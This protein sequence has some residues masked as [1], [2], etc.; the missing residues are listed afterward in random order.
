MKMRVVSLFVALASLALIAG[1]GGEPP[2]SDLAAA[3]QSLDAARAAGAEKFA[4]SDYS[5]AQSA[6]S[7]AEQSVNTEN[8]KLFKNF[9]QAKQLIT[10]AKGKA[11]R[12][13][14][15]ADSEKGRQRSSAEG[16]I[17]AVAAALQQAR[18]S[19]D[20]APAGKGT[21]SDI[22]QLRADLNG[23]DAD[24]G[25]ARSA[26]ASENF[27]QAKTRAGSAQQKAQDV[28]GGVQAATQKYEE[29]V[30]KMRPWYDRI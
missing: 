16:I 19:L 13:K 10:D 4:S 27:D 2:T 9:D 14:S 6:Y 17:S 29:L 11:D 28:S 23:A 26:V 25:A 8:E 30:E 22:E 12:A 20:G 21:E 5:A 7:G 1:C 18:A 15:A 3:K 24:L